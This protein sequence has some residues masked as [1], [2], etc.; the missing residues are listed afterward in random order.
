MKYITH[1]YTPQSILGP[2]WSFAALGGG[3]ILSHLKIH[4]GITG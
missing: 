1:L 3:A 2:T 4:Q